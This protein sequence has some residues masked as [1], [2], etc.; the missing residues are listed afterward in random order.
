MC[1]LGKV[2]QMRRLLLAGLA[3][4]ALAPS[5]FAADMAP[6]PIPP[7]L[8]SWTGFYVGGNVGWAG[9]TDAVTNFGTDSGTGGVGTAPL[10][11]GIPGIVNLN[12]TGVI[13]G[14]Q[15]G[16][17]WQIAPTWAVGVE[18]DFQGTNAKGSNAFA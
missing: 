5:A 10:A 16:Y 12:E 3:L 2:T 4:G 9:S 13:G 11:R 6:L 8:P 14:G 1:A 15:V 7:P 18:A 17:N